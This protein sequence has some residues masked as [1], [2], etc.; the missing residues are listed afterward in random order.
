MFDIL[1]Q[2]GGVVE[3]NICPSDELKHVVSSLRSI[4]QS[5]V[6]SDKRLQC[7]ITDN[8]HKDKSELLPAM[9]MFNY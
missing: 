4:W 5:Q 6:D 7:Y 1:N 2:N 3:V 9:I 8:V